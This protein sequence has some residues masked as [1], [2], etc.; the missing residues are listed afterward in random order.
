MTTTEKIQEGKS[1]QIGKTAFM[2]Q[3]PE[4]GSITYRDTYL[5]SDISR[6]NMGLAPEYFDGVDGV[7]NELMGIYW[8]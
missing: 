7:W 1:C 3:H 8:V 5:F 4:F 2:W 6:I